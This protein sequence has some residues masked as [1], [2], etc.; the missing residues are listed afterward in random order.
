MSY[1]VIARKY[2]P[3]SFQDVVGQSHI[4]QTLSNAIK[5]NRI[6]HALLFTGP[7][8]TGKT[9]SARILAK[10]LRC[11]NPID[12]S[13]LGRIPCQN[14]S[15]C[16]EI[17]ESRSV[18]V[19]EID[20]ASNNGVDNIRELRETVN[21]MP[22]QGDYKIFIIDEVHMLSGS[23]F[24]AL[25]KTLEEPPSHVIFIM[26]TTEVHKIPATILSR[27]QRFDFKRISIRQIVQHLTFICDLEKIQYDAD[28]LWIIA[29]QGDGSMRDSESLLDQVIS[30]SNGHLEKNS[31]QQILGLNHR[32]FVFEAFNHILKR[33]PDSMVD[34]LRKMKSIGVESD[35]FMT[36]L[37][38]LSRHF[39]LIKTVANAAL[40]IIDLPESEFQWLAEKTKDTTSE[41][42]HL[43]FQLIV[44][45]YEDLERTDQAYVALE[46]LLMRLC[47][48]P[49]LMD[50]KSLLNSGSKIPATQVQTQHKPTQPES[51]HLKTLNRTNYVT[52][53]TSA[54][55]WLHFVARIK[56]SEPLF[57]AKIENLI[58]N[59]ES[60]KKI[61]LGVTKSN[62]FLK[63][64]LSD[65]DNKKK[66]QGFVDSFWGA[67]YSFM[68]STIQDNQGESAQSMAQKKAL[69]NED[70]I[71]KQ[72]AQEP[73]IQVAQRIFKGSIKSVS[74]INT[75]TKKL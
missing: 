41:D 68:V 45:A 75:P 2:R 25:L 51:T 4:T 28:S 55:K 64:L 44:K 69:Q 3:Q 50:L 19:I 5:N 24:N 33:N 47:L 73:K 18:D 17:S 12:D 36:E 67:G 22:S 29:K 6:P 60:S 62:S 1:Q 27:C 71:Q 30:F 15:S 11:L 40:D 56:S 63:D 61:Q 14:C 46:M 9:S 32:D 54:E 72:L 58:F 66:M 35:I 59:S 37:I 7:R 70:E 23:A 74:E 13:T 26:A 65:A 43:L 21:Y 20:G 49:K 42:I 10:V 57:G 8:G 53:V 16:V 48:A 31:T 39:L 34:L 38:E 52:G